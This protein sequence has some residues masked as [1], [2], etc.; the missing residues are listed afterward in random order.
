MRQHLGLAGIQ[1]P[2]LDGWGD[3]QVGDYFNALGGLDHGGRNIQM[4]AS[5]KLAKHSA[6]HEDPRSQSGQEL[7]STDPREQD[8][9]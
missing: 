1:I 7:Q 5:P 6:R 9:R 4:G 8:E 2:R 3:R